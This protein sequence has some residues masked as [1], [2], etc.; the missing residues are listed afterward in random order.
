MGLKVVLLLNGGEKNFDVILDMI[1]QKDIIVMYFVFVMLYVFFEFME[2][3][4]FGELK[5]KFE[6][7]RYV[8]V[9]G[10]VLMFVYVF[11]FYCLIILVGKV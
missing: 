3:K 11:G 6:I 7:L 8:F 10:E 2:Q 4:F 9:S 1:V 5:R